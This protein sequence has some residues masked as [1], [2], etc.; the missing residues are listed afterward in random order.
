MTFTDDDLKRLKEFLPYKLHVF[1]I[2]HGT[3]STLLARLEA[4]ENIAA[5]GC[6]TRRCSVKLDEACDCEMPILFKAWRKAC[7]RDK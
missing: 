4:A 6:H 1:S 2:S 7:G 5:W 3:V